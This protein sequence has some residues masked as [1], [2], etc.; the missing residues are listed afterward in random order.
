VFRRLDRLAPRDT[1][2][3][4]SASMFVTTE[5]STEVEHHPG[6]CLVVHP[7]NP[8][9]VVP[10]VEVVPGART[11]P[12][13]GV[14]AYEFMKAVGQEPILLR[15]EIFGFV[16]NRLQFALEREAF[17]LA[18]EDV[19]SVADIDKAVSHGLGLRWAFLGPFAVEATNNGGI[20]AALSGYNINTMRRLISDVAR[21][22]DGPSEKD[23]A[24]VV[25]AMDGRPGDTAHE[26]L[27]RYRDRMVRRLRELKEGGRP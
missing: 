5:I 7:T 11:D 26:D 6:R 12:G 15:K 1:I 14:A 25:D 9:H 18:R 20:G 27:S 16:L 8:P 21:P 23:I 10:L 2:L 3:A 13:V 4:S 22:Y 19:A 24:L 17:Y